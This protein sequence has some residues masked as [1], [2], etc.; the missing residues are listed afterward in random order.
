MGNCKTGVIQRR[1]ELKTAHMTRIGRRT[2]DAGT[3]ADVRGSVA[4]PFWG[5]QPRVERPAG[6]ALQPPDIPV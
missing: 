2:A 1:D 4:I 5:R 3:S 6:V